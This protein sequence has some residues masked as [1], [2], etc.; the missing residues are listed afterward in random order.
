MMMTR[1]SVGYSSQ[2]PF[3]QRPESHADTTTLEYTSQFASAD[4][5]PTLLRQ[6]SI[7]ELDSCIYH[8]R[9]APCIEL[10]WALLR[11]QLSI[12]E[13]TR[14]SARL[15]ITVRHRLSRWAMVN[16]VHVFLC[17][18][19]TTLRKLIAPPRR[20]TLSISTMRLYSTSTLL[21]F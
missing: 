16:S 20:P 14:W 13:I 8:C 17:C 7:Y 3:G 6:A 5:Q 15:D 18:L 2:R 4:I 12:D 10:L 11:G 1:R 19:F 21:L 9:G